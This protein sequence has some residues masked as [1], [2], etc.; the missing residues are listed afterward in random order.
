MG[1][2]KIS[3]VTVC[4]NAANSIE[5]TIKSVINQTYENIEYIIIDGGSTDG[6]VDIIKKYE[7][8]ISY[9]VSEPDHGIYDAM[10]KGIAVAT[11]GYIN[12]MNAG[13]KFCSHETL[14]EFVPQISESTIIAFGN[15]HI[16]L[17]GL[18][19]SRKPLS[20]KYLKRQIPFCH[21]AAFYQTK[22]H[23]NHLF[24]PELKLVADY[25]IVYDAYCF[26]HVKFQYIPLY[27]A[28]Y[29]ITLGHSA[30]VDSYRRSLDEKY[31]IWGI[32]NK[33]LKKIPH[34]LYN[35]YT[36]LSYQIRKLLPSKTIIRIKGLKNS[37]RA[38]YK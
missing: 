36:A 29:D 30:S 33:P 26:D 4:Y 17:N 21:Q 23:K 28:D 10:N 25:K 35:I 22:Y 38:H 20:W 5:G 2:I 34:E 14:N 13:D 31:L 37:L 18:K 1:G 6:T 16:T 11:G 8:R 32:K 15:W 9:W 27:V 19:Q 12:F 24:S 3:V 7:D